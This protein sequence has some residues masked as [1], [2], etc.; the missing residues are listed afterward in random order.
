MA[1]ELLES[2]EI[3]W[4]QLP[5]EPD[6]LFEW[7]ECYKNL[8]PERSIARA[9][10]MWYKV[11][12][13]VTPKPGG[14]WNKAAKTYLWEDRASLWDKE[15]RAELR[16][17]D[18]VE[19][20]QNIA[21]RRNILKL[22]YNKLITALNTLQPEAATWKE[23]ISGVNMITENLRIEF[24]DTPANKHIIET[25]GEGTLSRKIKTYRTVSPDDWDI[26]IAAKQLTGGTSPHLIDSTTDS[27]SEDTN[28]KVLIDG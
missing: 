17:L 8:G 19:H 23:V 18:E 24:D 26:S 28:E 13:K 16:Q 11:N 9:Y 22:A 4:A 12:N 5:G 14:E 20:S 15:K 27:I 10:Q 2:I 3:P 6:L 7:F 1:E 25:A 21:A